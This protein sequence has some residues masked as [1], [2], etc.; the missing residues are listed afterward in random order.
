MIYLSSPLKLTNSQ[1][2]V[3]RNFVDGLG[4][5]K[6]NDLIKRSNLTIEDVFLAVNNEIPTLY[7]FCLD[8]LLLNFGV[9]EDTIPTA[10]NWYGRFYMYF[11]A[12]DDYTAI[13]P[14]NNDIKD[15]NNLLSYKQANSVIFDNRLFCTITKS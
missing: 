12:I 3:D 4:Q 7:A 2:Q 11:P 8:D 9:A 14:T 6:D 1:S 10:S 5:P 13:R 15:A